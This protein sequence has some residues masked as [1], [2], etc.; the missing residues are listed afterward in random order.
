[1]QAEYGDKVADEL[2]GQ[3]AYKTFLRTGSQVTALWAQTHF[4]QA[5]QVRPQVLGVPLS[6]SVRRLC[7]ISEQY[8]LRLC[9]GEF[10]TS[11]R[12]YEPST[13][14]PETGL[15]GYHDT[16][17]FGAYRTRA[18]WDWVMSSL[19]EP[20][21]ELLKSVKKVSARDSS[22]QKLHAWERK[23]S[24]D[25]GQKTER[26]KAKGKRAKNSSAPPPV[27][28][29]AKHRHKRLRLTR[30]KPE[31]PGPA[32]GTR[33]LLRPNQVTPTHRRTHPGQRRRRRRRNTR[34]KG[35]VVPRSSGPGTKSDRSR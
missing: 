11:I 30:P 3:C 34:P 19:W 26:D 5:E 14:G 2:A 21:E 17:R 1:M 22:E 9:R 4:G 7:R 33:Q 24:S 32:R 35:G 12:T 6:R 25:C 31:I 10:R 27:Q 29:A 18:P 20:S 13:P 16:P 28:D 8:Q 15:V 23:T